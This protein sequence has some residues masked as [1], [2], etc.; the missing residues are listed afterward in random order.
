MDAPKLGFFR[1]PSQRNYLTG[2]RATGHCSCCLS[3]SSR[4]HAL[5]TGKDPATWQVSFTMAHIS[6]K[7][8][9]SG[10]V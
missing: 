6:K 5:E 7:H 10:Q 9:T 2:L 8:R 4:C 1:A 3:L